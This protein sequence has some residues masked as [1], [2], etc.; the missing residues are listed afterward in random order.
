M[1]RLQ[2]FGWTASVALALL[3]APSAASATDFYVNGTTG[4]DV[5]GNSC[6]SPT[7]I[8]PNGPCQT[9]DAAIARAQDS[10]GNSVLLADGDYVDNNGITLTSGITLSSSDGDVD[11]K[12]RVITTT[13][14]IDT[15]NGSIDHLNIF[16]STSPNV[17]VQ[18]SATISDNAFTAVALPPLSF[19]LRVG[20]EGPDDT[21]V[22]QRNVFDDNGAGL[23]FAINRELG[24]G[25]VSILDN[26]ISDFFTGIRVARGTAPA[27]RRNTITGT[28]DNGGMASGAAVDFLGGCGAAISDNRINS[29]EPASST[30]SGIRLSTVNEGVCADLARNR[31]VGPFLVG[32]DLT[33][34]ASVTLDS[35]LITGAAVGLSTFD[36][37]GPL[38]NVT[39]T[40]ATIFDNTVGEIQTQGAHVTLN[41]VMTGDVV[42]GSGGT[43]S[44][45]FSRG[46]VAAGTPEDTSNCD[47]F[48][49]AADPLFTGDYHLMPG[50][51]MI[52]AGDPA[53]PPGGALDFDGDQR[54]L[55][56]AA[57][58]TLTAGRRDIG[59]D[60][61]VPAIGVGCPS[62]IP[63]VAGPTGQR[64]AA[65]KK[66]AK[67][68]S[69]RKKKKC[70]KRARLLPV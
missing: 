25:T 5:A 2:R 1:G 32:L 70:K 13:I 14:T 19:D 56:G 54:A 33:D 36:S 21:V 47:D 59:A 20:G 50:S 17:Q 44:I 67:I 62:A 27:I 7:G 49:T 31:V 6:Q 40:N 41:S 46:D 66:C 16:G 42:A 65:L 63:P 68:K 29:P 69:K 51:T 61:F 30:L 37:A 4:S 64:A 34:T 15:N 3:V 60:E 28:H 55:S 24:S 58:C 23:Q 38:G 12:P 22:I 11:P 39:A 45:S 9:I 57:S 18:G 48:Q 8:P 43:C 35:D 10:A 53:D 26:T 52:D